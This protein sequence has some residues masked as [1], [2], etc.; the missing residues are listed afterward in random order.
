MVGWLWLGACIACTG[1]R[2]SAAPA[3]A[4]RMP[5]AQSTPSAPATSTGQATTP[6]NSAEAVPLAAAEAPAAK[7]AD[8][9]GHP[10]DPVNAVLALDG[11]ASTSLGGPSSGHLLGGIALPDRGPGFFHNP[12]RPDQARFGTVELVQAIVRAAAAVERDLPGSSL[13]VNDLGLEAGG[14]IAQHGS[15][16]AGRDADILFYMQD[17]HGQPIPAVG[18]PIDPQ[19]KGI[20]FKDLSV[21][22]DD[23]PEQL[24]RARTWHFVAALLEQ[25]EDAVQR[26]FLVEH[27]RSMLLAEAKRVHAPAAI[28]QR[29]EDVT[30]QPEAPHDD[31]LH[32]RL[33]CT[34]QDMAQGCLDSPPTYPWRLQALKALG[35]KPLLASTQRNKEESDAR[36][37]RTTTPAEARKKAGPMHA[38]VVKFLAQR[39]AWIKRPSPGRPYCR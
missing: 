18:V 32:V 5:A 13:A 37:K 6:A 9:G 26:I 27:V 10:L 31:H 23:Q 29:F 19:G 2:E 39:E 21:P 35:L 11:S 20:D 30:C 7:A 22:D 4:P 36:A 17:V 24:D 14:P 34:P 25:T 38:D 16:Q 1:T 33:Y 15:H 12:I 3:Q 28:V 8:G